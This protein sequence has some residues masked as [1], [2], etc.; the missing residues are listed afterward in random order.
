MSV[1]YFGGGR[2]ADQPSVIYLFGSGDER[3]ISEL[4]RS[5]TAGLD[6]VARGADLHRGSDITVAEVSTMT[7]VTAQGSH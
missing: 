7:G 4:V 5:T 2:F 3:E 6:E 1:D